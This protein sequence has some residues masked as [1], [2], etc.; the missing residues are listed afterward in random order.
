MIHRCRRRCNGA[1]M[2]AIPDLSSTTA[3]SAVD[4]SIEGRDGPIQ[5]RVY[6]ASG[7]AAAGA[8]QAPTGSGLV[9]VHGGGF[10]EGTLDWPE[11]DHTARAFAARGMDV[12]SVDYRLCRNG[13]HWPAPSDDVL[14]AWGW[15]LDHALELGVDPAKL[16]LGGAS[17]GGNLAAGAVLRLLEGPADRLPARVFLAYPTLH[18]VQP[19][20]PADI[21]DLLAGLTDPEVFSAPNVLA[22]YQN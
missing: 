7:D 10:G 1:N 14:D 3:A 19:E 2:S 6:L 12:G 11:A 22:M 8:Q 21:K 17:A 20:T 18:A 16:V 9:W 15:A 5:V 13:V 4:R